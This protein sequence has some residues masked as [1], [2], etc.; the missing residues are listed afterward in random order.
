MTKGT[1]VDTLCVCTRHDVIEANNVFFLSPTADFVAQRTVAQ[2]ALVSN[3]EG[4][5]LALNLHRTHRYTWA[6]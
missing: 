1:L 5:T 6:T 3:P 2:K 4:L